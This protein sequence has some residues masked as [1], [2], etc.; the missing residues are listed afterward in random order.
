M[1]VPRPPLV[2]DA[3][4]E[5]RLAADEGL[6]DLDHSRQSTGNS[7]PII[8]HLADRMAKLPR[9]LLVHAQNA[10]HHDRRNAL[11]GG[12]HEEHRGDP[13]PEIQLR[14]V[15]RRPRGDGELAAAFPLN[16]LIQAG[17]HGCTSQ[18]ARIQAAAMWTEPIIAPDGVLEEEPRVSFGRHLLPDIADGLQFGDHGVASLRGG[19]PR[20]LADFS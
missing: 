14:R 15:E 6:V 4:A 9:G 17:A 19:E 3:M 12:Q 1:P 7:L 20:R 13:G 2:L 5:L 18:R 10:R 11:G 8:H 16:A